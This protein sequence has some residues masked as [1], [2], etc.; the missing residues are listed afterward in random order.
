MNRNTP[1]PP[2][3]TPLIEGVQVDL[4]TRRVEWIERT[5]EIDDIL[6]GCI[7]ICSYTED[8]DHERV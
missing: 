4:D 6:K 2:V 3:T 7:R 5:K 8:I 1:F